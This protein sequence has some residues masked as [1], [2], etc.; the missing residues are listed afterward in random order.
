[1]KHGY[2]EGSCFPKPQGNPIEI[3][4]QGAAVLNEIL[5]DPGMTSYLLPDGST[6]VYAPN[7]RGG[8]FRKDGTFKGFIEYN[9]NEQK[10]TIELCSD[11]DFEGMAVY[12]NYGRELIA[13]LNY[14]KGINHIEVEFFPSGK[15]EGQVVCSLS[16]FLTTL[17][18]AKNLAIKCAKE[19]EQ[20]R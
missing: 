8:F 19:D 16:D 7:G 9:I 6:K 10:F 18:K 15:G 11:L 20:Q 3:N 14:E 12:V 5:S 1:M 17:E 2:R 13:S 4:Q